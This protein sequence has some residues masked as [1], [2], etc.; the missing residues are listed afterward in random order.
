MPSRLPHL[1]DLTTL[2]V[3]ALL[4]CRQAPAVLP[5]KLDRTEIAPSHDSGGQA[6]DPQDTG[7]ADD[8]APEDSAAPEDSGEPADGECILVP[9]PELDAD[10]VA[11]ALQASV[12]GGIPSPMRTRQ[13]YLSMFEGRDPGCP[14]GSQPNLPGRFEGCWSESGWFYAGYAEYAGPVDPDAHGESFTLLADGQMIDGDGGVFVGAGQL[15]YTPEPGTGRWEGSLSGTWSHDLADDWM[16]GSGAGG[17]LTYL[18]DAWASGWRLEVSGSVGGVAHPIVLQDVVVWSDDCT[19]EGADTETAGAST[20]GA[21]RLRGSAG[22]WYTLA[23]DDCGCG[24]VTYDDGSELGEA[25]V[26]LGPAAQALAE[27]RL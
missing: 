18:A 1:P 20:S 4:G 12:S 17:V 21:L 23:L 13:V 11:A 8:T 7:P 10:G 22:Y 24:P 5:W 2:A 16:G 15:A 3:V 25:C 19:A 6:D 27:W 26:Q 9:A 14:G